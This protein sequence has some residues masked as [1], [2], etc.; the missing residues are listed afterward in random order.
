MSIEPVAGKECSAIGPKQPTLTAYP[1]RDAMLGDLR[2]YR[3]M[4]IRDRR[5]VGP[6][7]FLDRFGALAFA[8]DKPMNVPPHPHIG[9][10]TVSWLVEGEV[11]HNDSLGSEA[12]VRPGGVNVMTAGRGI[13][14]AEETPAKNSGRLNGVQ[15]WVALPEIH[16]NTV[17]SFTSVEQVSV[18]ETR[19]GIV[20]VFAG[21][22]AGVPSSAPYFSDIIGM[23]IQIHKR[24]AVELVLNPEFEHA[25]LVLSSDCW[26]ENQHLEEHTLYYLG[27]RRSSLTLKSQESGRILVIGGPPFPETILMWWNFVAR[28]S[29]EIVQARE[30]WEAHRRFGEVPGEHGPRLAA[31]SLVRFARPNLVS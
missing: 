31:P 10:Q 1:N 25:A 13:A 22:Y 2:I 29:E 26:L 30:D 16:R 3:A 11:L 28:T 18:L 7:C 19:G 6:W 15:L 24:E 9:I 17:P 8:A 20:Q 27:S 14:H 23:D 21:S 12:I 4:P 5:L